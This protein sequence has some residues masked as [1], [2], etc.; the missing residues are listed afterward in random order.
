MIKT[1]FLRREMNTRFL[2]MVKTLSF[3][4]TVE[5]ILMHNLRLKKQLLVI[6]KQNLIKKQDLHLTI[7]E[8]PRRIKPE[9]QMNDLWAASTLMECASK[10]DADAVA[11]EKE[12]DD[13]SETTAAK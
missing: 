8:N 1:R 7:F 9:E 10:E 3:L 12:A 4:R 2:R 6:M 13:N 5:R 11:A